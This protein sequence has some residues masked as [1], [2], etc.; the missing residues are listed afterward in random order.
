MK[1]FQHFFERIVWQCVEAGL[2]EGR[3]LFLGSRLVEADASKNS[4]LDTQSLKAQLH[5]DYAQL[6]AR[7]EEIAKERSAHPD[8]RQT[9]R[10]FRFV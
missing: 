1:L 6:E 4:I 10:R 5:R 3:K 7:L 8:Y 9:N 2:V